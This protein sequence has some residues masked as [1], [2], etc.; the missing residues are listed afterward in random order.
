M[1]TET[2]GLQSYLIKGV[3]SQRSRMQ[4]ANILQPASELDMVVYHQ[5]HKNFQIVK[6][7]QVAHIRPVLQE[8]VL[9]NCIALFCMEVL[10]QFLVQDDVQPELF[11]FCKDFLQQLSVLPLSQ[12]SN[13][14]LFF[15]IQAGRLSGYRLSGCYS[16]ATTHL[17][18]HEGHFC[19]S[20][21]HFPPFIEG[22]EA[23]LMSL[24]NEAETVAMINNIN[25][26]ND[27]RRNALQ[28]YLLLFRIHAP[29]FKELKSLPVLMAIL[30][31]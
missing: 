4:R 9:R 10:A 28:H 17:D 12:V 2:F 26:N 5:P 6:E 30:S 3:R 29:H 20:Q 24:L 25:I 13:L 23:Q 16:N 15:L 8:E 18:L 14:P 27:A 22:E 31:E 7:F 21:G 19:N 1:F 11:L